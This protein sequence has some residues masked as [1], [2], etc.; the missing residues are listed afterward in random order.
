MHT[1]PARSGLCEY[2]TGVFLDPR[3]V[4]THLPMTATSRVGDFGAGAGHY[5]FAAAERLGPEGAVYAIEAHEPLVDRLH[6][7]GRAFAPS[8]YAIHA[9]LNRHVPLRDSLLDLAIVANVLHQIKER[10]RFLFELL[11]V[12]RPGGKAL[13]VDWASS[14]RNMGPPAEE[15]LSPGEAAR[16]T[17]KVGFSV[18]D[19]LPAGSHHFAFVASAADRS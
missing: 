8:F 19:M 5:A 3:E 12:L 4:M 14:F 10:E 17:R 9:D 15:V 6:R 1:K 16:L 2:N 7:E 13:I 11:R 18:S